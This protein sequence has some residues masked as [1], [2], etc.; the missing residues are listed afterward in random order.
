[1]IITLE[2]KLAH[3]SS[4]YIIVDVG[5]V[6][7]KVALSSQAIASMPEPGT[8]VKVWTYLYA[9]ENETTELYGFLTAVEL[10]FF[11]LLITVSGV[12]PKGAQA[13]LS[14][15]A[16]ENIKRAIA[17]GDETILTRVSGIGKKIAEKII[18]ELKDKFSGLEFREGKAPGDIADA[19]EA[20]EQLGYSQKEA[21]ET[22]QQ[23]SKK[24][25]TAEEQVKEALKILGGK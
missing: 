7:Y 12:G 18:F 9:R 6:G 5:G 22:L 2:G 19:I 24:A 8:I 21:R 4:A 20:L 13:I 3:K 23:V 17:S 15:A 14:V 10:E 16:V 25:K 11:E 1:M